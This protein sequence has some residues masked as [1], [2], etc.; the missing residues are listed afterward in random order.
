MCIYRYI[1]ILN[2]FI[3]VVA[4]GRKHRTLS[5]KRTQLFANPNC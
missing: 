4:Q 1:Y 5:E 2:K 3:L